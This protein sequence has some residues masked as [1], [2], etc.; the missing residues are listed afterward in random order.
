VTGYCV[1]KKKGSFEALWQKFDMIDDI[2]TSKV[3][4]PLQQLDVDPSKT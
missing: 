3:F 4:F 2:S 1:I